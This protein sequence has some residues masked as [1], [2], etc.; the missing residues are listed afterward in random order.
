[1]PAPIPH[2]SLDDVP[3]AAML[4]ALGDPVRL[5]IVAMAAEEDGLPCRAFETAIPK[6]TMSS[7]WR[8]LR[9]AGLIRQ[10]G[11]GTARINSLRKAEVD[12]RFPG[13][14]DAVLAQRLG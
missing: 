5:S 12:A 4:H 6:S 7:H 10:E 2:P 3:L 13:L 9:E 11:R 14:L 8:V 1:M